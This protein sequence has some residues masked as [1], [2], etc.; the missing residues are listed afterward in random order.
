MTPLDYNRNMPQ[1]STFEALSQYVEGYP[2]LAGYITSLPE[3]AIFR[4]FGA[5]N[6]RNLLYLQAELTDLEA[7]LLQT[8]RRDNV[9]PKWEKQ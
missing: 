4:R 6:A 7:A 8:E 9:H 3:V 5:M 2:K 1:S